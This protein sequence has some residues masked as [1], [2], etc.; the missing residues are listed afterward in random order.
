VFLKRHH[1]V[2][3]V[4]ASALLMQN[5]DTA[6][7]ATALPAASDAL[8]EPPV[9]LHL[10]LTL[11]MLTVGI[12]L[13]LTS[14]AADRVGART[15]FG[16]SILVF[17]LGS[18][19]SGFSS[20]LGELL[21]GRVLQ[22]MG[23]AMLM[24]VARVILVT[25]VERRQLVQAM[26][27]MG[28]ATVIGPALGPVLG[29]LCVTYLSWRWIFWINVPVGAVSFALVMLLIENVRQENS[30]R[31]DLLGSALAALGLS[32]ALFGVDAWASDSAPRWLAAGSLAT[33]VVA[34]LLCIRHSRR[35]A[36]AVLDLELFRVPTYRASA[37]G[38]A[39]FR[40][41]AGA[42]PFL[43][44]LMMQEGLGY[45]P[46][47]S[48][49]ITFT[50]ALGALA[51]RA[52]TSLI[53][54]RLGFA[55]V[56]K[57][58]AIIVALFMAGYGFFT[59]ETPYLVMAVLL[60]VG[61]LFRALQVTCVNAIAY[62]ELSQAQTSQ[63]ASLMEMS[64]RLAQTLGIA[65]AA[66]FLQQFADAEGAIPAVAFTADLL[67]IAAVSGLSALVFWRLPA[68]AGAELL[69]RTAP[70]VDAG[71]SSGPPDPR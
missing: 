24:P 35:A 44:P 12:F 46:L 21:A 25:S 1:V 47:A 39:L 49:L 45:S 41:G 64:R 68:G 28:M 6:A 33:G 22:G 9:R 38:G 18:I 58:N 60:F 67:M 29:G 36:H 53:V 31:L 70:S 71:V 2:A 17:G 57:W 20:G 37:L 55:P 42:L 8:G 34:I 65:M 10:A 26:A 13:P 19:V 50:M 14:G 16:A 62:A 4:V 30:R 5:L 51:A 15:I 61:G 52:A 23:G 56:L 48:G 59:A 54:N 32:G 27:V 43:L 40:I 69:D 7:L 66:A 63:A 3:L 11:Y